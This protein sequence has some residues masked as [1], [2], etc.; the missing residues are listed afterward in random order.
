LIAI[1]LA[2][3]GR[4]F[5][6]KNT[7]HRPGQRPILPSSLS[8]AASQ[9]DNTAG[10]IHQIELSLT[11]FGM[12]IYKVLPYAKSVFHLLTVAVCMLEFYL[13]MNL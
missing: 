13:S 8:C 1:F 5:I 3:I 6:K 10:K 2:L 12:T 11:G 4:K 9:Y 7:F